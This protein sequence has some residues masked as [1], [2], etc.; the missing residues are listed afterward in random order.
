[1]IL[2]VFD[3]DRCTACGAPRVNARQLC[4]TWKPGLGDMVA[5]GLSSV[6]ITVDRANA[7]AQFLGYDECRCPER[8]EAMNKAG[9]AFGIGSPPEVPRE[10]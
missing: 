6:G 2:C 3:G 10:G 4:G 9:S 7:V 5:F 8:Q 1:M